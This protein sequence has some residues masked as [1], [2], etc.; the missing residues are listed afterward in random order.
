MQTNG[1][2]GMKLNVQDLVDIK[3]AHSTGKFAG[4]ANISQFAKALGIERIAALKIY[5]GETTSISFDVLESICRVLEC[6]PNDIL[7]SED[8]QVARSLDNFKRL[9]QYYKELNQKDDSE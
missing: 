7:I 9:Q 5:N 2:E 3:F 8:L 4:Q 6:T 1:V